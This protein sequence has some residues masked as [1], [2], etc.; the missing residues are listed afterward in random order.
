MKHVLLAVLSLA[1]ASTADASALLNFTSGAAAALCDTRVAVS[2]VN[3]GAGFTV[4]GDTIAYVGAIGTWQIDTLAITT[5]NTPGGPTLGKINL[6]LVDVRHLSGPDDLTVDFGHD[7]FT[8]PVGQGP[9]TATG[10]DSA[11]TVVAGDASYLTGYARNA[12]DMAIAAPT[13]ATALDVILHV[14]GCFPAAGVTQSC[15]MNSP[16]V[17]F[18]VVGPFYS[19]SARAEIHQHTSALDQASYLAKAAA[20][21][22]V[23]PEPATLILIGTGLLALAARRRRVR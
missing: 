1:L 9:L 12:N 22:P 10:A 19:L 8:A 3:C 13:S 23:V 6:G 15:A 5:S 11:D 4:V 7:G 14:P 20:N 2:A 21:V 16:D 17:P 18:T